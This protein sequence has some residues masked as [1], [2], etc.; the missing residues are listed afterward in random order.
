MSNGN[1]KP[2]RKKRNAFPNQRSAVNV[3]VWSQDG[4]PVSER[5]LNDIS[6]NIAYIAHQNNLLTQVTKA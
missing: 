1:G 3:S 2:S 4:S 5:V 6:G